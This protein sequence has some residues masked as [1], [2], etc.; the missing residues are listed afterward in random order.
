LD[1]SLTEARIGQVH[2]SD[3]PGTT[4]PREEATATTQFAH[5]KIQ[6]FS[7]KMFMRG[8]LSPK[9]LLYCEKFNE[10]S[11]KVKE[12]Y[13]PGSRMAARRVRGLRIEAPGCS[14]PGQWISDRRLLIA[15]RHAHCGRSSNMNWQI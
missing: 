14:L 15:G 7:S 13:V 4:L 11:L 6:F 8:A 10:I 12:H 5:S 2:A 3:I 9:T 1:Q